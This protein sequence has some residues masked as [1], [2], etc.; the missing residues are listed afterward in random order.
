MHSV[1]FTV[2]RRAVSLDTVVRPSCLGRCHLH[3]SSAPIHPHRPFPQSSCRDV[4]RGPPLLRLCSTAVFSR[5]SQRLAIN[6]TEEVI[7]I[8]THLSWLSPD[9]HREEAEPVLPETTGKGRACS[10]GESS[11]MSEPGKQTGAEETVTGGAVGA[12]G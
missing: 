10:Y 8:N 11:R 5:K 9:W 12:S 3:S 1:A 7:H 6:L 4:C 2:P